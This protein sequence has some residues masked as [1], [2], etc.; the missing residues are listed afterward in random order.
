MSA[1][2]FC[3]IK[4]WLANQ[5][6][7]ILS[8]PC[9]SYAIWYSS[10]NTASVRRDERR[11]AYVTCIWILTNWAITNA[12]L[13][14]P[15]FVSK[16]A[17]ITYFTSCWGTT[18]ITV[19]GTNFIWAGSRLTRVNKISVW[20]YLTLSLIFTQLTICSAGLVRAHTSLKIPAHHA[21]QASKITCALQAEWNCNIAKFTNITWPIWC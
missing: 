5:A 14:N 2:S 8:S 18:L 12:R 19:L 16:K 20:T 15:I 17:W 10:A 11:Q 6:S 1:A 7:R 9:I 13:T 21:F 4:S 3:I